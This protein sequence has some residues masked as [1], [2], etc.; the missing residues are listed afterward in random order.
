MSQSPHKAGG[1]DPG[2]A[3]D[4]QPAAEAAGAGP[5]THRHLTWLQVPTF[6]HLVA[7]LGLH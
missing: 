2:S 1:Y 5:D 6:G 3:G 4:P 7:S